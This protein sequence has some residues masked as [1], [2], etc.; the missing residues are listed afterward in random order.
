LC[1]I[2]QLTAAAAGGVA[3]FYWWRSSRTK[4]PPFTIEPTAVH[5]W[6]TAAA[7]DNRRGAGAAAVASAL[8]ALATLLMPWCV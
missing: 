7:H 4:P 5:A 8:T 1:T 3:A 6:L 2:L